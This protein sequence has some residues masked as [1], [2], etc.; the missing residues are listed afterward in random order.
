MIVQGPPS[1]LRLSPH[2]GSTW[3]NSVKVKVVST[4]ASLPCSRPTSQKTCG[5]CPPVIVVMWQGLHSF[6]RSMC[7]LMVTLAICFRKEVQPEPFLLVHVGSFGL[8]SQVEKGVLKM[9]GVSW[10]C[11]DLRSWCCGWLLSPPIFEA[12]F[13]GPQT[14]LSLLEIK[15]VP[16]QQ[17]PGCAVCTQH[18]YFVNSL[19]K[20]LA[21]KCRHSGLR[22]LK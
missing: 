10:V 5:P 20:C 9:A 13:P 4:E 18:L 19:S 7:D 11:W 3:Q 14:H 22:Y 1:L 12:L 2:L 6:T 16:F 8:H 17:E 15:C 21:K